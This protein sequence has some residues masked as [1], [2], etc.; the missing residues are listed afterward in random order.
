[1]VLEK[2]DLHAFTDLSYRHQPFINQVARGLPMPYMDPFHS[3][4]IICE[5][6]E[7]WQCRYHDWLANSSTNS[8]TANPPSR[9][10]ST[11]GSWFLSGSQVLRDESP[12]EVLQALNA[13]IHKHSLLPGNHNNISHI[14]SVNI[15]AVSTLAA[16][17]KESAVLFTFAMA[18]R[19]DLLIATLTSFY[20]AYLRSFPTPV[21]VFYAAHTPFQ[22]SVIQNHFQDIADL[23]LT[24]LPI[25][26][27]SSNGTQQTYHPQQKAKHGAVYS[28][29]TLANHSL[30]QLDKYCINPDPDSYAIS[31]FLR[32]EAFR[33]LRRLGFDWFIRFADDASF[34][35]PL[36]E[37]LISHVLPKNG[38]SEDTSQPKKKYAYL[39]AMQGRQ[40]C[41]RSLWAF[42]EKFCA[43]LTPPLVPP[44][45]QSNS[46]LITYPQCSPL[47]KQWNEGLYLLASLEIS[48]SSVW[49]S[50]LCSAL[51][52]SLAS[53]PESVNWGDAALHTLC[54]LVSLRPDEIVRLDDRVAYEVR[55]SNAKMQGT[56]QDQRM[57]LQA[58]EEVN[59][60]VAELS[61]ALSMQR[62]GWLGGD[63]ATSIPFPPSPH[64]TRAHS[65]SPN[66]VLW[67]FGDSII[68]AASQ[69]KRLN[70]E[71]GVVANTVGMMQL[72]SEEFRP[73]RSST[74]TQ[75]EARP[76]SV[77]R[78]KYY[79]REEVRSRAVQ[80]IFEIPE[81]QHSNVCGDKGINSSNFSGEGGKAAL[82]L[83][84]GITLSAT[85][86][87]SNGNNHNS[88]N[89][90][91][92]YHLFYVFLICLI[93]R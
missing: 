5:Y 48:H 92:L 86:S 47:F 3:D 83:L 82:W 76:R 85:N 90:K 44:S 29:F 40:E 60:S 38:S 68:G 63:V 93:Y 88:Q 73:D 23:Q 89:G 14:R 69:T 72:G 81:S 45:Q 2:E 9:S 91:F 61:Q 7:S 36:S 33:V 17:G 15:S 26:F 24:F 30:D 41:S 84:S 19:E 34:L 62:L 22:V 32:T 25:T 4:D 59:G 31:M 65:Q 39:H 57:Q 46:S 37:S 20:Q 71:Y 10:A 11:N 18:R 1:M 66:Q 12:V 78:M 64:F 8:S 75:C 70:Q 67:L 55:W 16:H 43:S 35:G 27:Q 21:V 49:E 58:Y 51:F 50:Y 13:R 6:Y 80:P 77:K 28:V 52:A 56:M 74:T 42:G 79:W 54:I 53:Q 87:Y